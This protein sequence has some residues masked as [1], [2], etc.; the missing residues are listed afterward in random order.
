MGQWM[1]QDFPTSAYFSL[2]WY[3]EGPTEP[4]FLPFMCCLRV[5]EIYILP[6]PAI[7]SLLMCSL[8]ISLTSPATLE[9][10]KVNFIFDNDGDYYDNEL[11]DDFRDA[12][13]WCPLDSIITHP[14]SSQLQRVDINM[15]FRVMELHEAGVKRLVLNALP[16]LCEKGILFVKVTVSGPVLEREMV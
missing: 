13:V 12:D 15:I 5:F 10:I 3:M 8:R 7:F 6:D 11:L 2:I 1:V 9:H 16:L 4:I 14:T